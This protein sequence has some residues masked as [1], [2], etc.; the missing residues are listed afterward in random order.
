DFGRSRDPKSHDFGYERTRE[1]KLDGELSAPQ[2]IAIV[3]RL[4]LSRLGRRGQRPAPSALRTSAD[5]TRPVA[6]VA[7]L[8]IAG[9][10]AGAE[11]LAPLEPMRAKPQQ[12]PQAAAGQC[13]Q[14]DEGSDG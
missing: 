6:P 10:T 8:L 7:D 2:T 3:N 11:H 13:S 9:G 4:R 1:S 5:M 12:G 14:R